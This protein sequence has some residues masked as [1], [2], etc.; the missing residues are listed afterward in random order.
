VAWVKRW[1]SQTPVSSHASPISTCSVRPG[2]P[3]A[4]VATSAYQRH[5]PG[6]RLC[7]M[8]PVCSPPLCWTGGQERG[9]ARAWV[10]RRTREGCPAPPAPHPP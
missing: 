9:G 7:P 4:V 3:H 5:T 6:H 8:H 2:L 10:R 1:D